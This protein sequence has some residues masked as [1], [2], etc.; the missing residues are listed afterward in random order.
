MGQVLHGSATTT[1]AVRRAIQHSQESLRA[2][3]SATG[4][5]RR[6]SPSGSSA[7]GRRPADRAER[8]KF[9]GPVDRG[10]GD[11]RRLPPAYAAAA[12]RLPLRPAGHHPA[13][14]ALVPASLP[15]APWHRP[16]AGCRGRQAAKKKF[17]AYPIGFFHIDIAEVQ[18]A[19]GNSISSWPSTA[20]AS[21]PSSQLVEKA[22]RV[23]ARPSWAP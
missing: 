23:T 17:K 10:R 22:N 14:D 20:P 11:H 15:A 6:R 2:W 21:S 8:A 1:E 7:L 9:D 3:P 5:T 4:S 19:E 16:A 18:T 13:S 12:R